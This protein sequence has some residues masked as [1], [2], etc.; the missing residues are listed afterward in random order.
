MSLLPQETILGKLEIIEIYEFYD[1]PCLFSCGNIAGQVFLVVW[2]DETSYSDSWLYVPVSRRRLQQVV[3]GGIELRSAF[4]EAEDG[5]VFEITIARNEKKT[6]VLTISCGN[7]QEESLP[8]S[9]EFLNCQSQFV[10]SLIEKKN[11]KI[12]AIQLN[13]VVLNL[14]FGFPTMDIMQAPIADLG[15]LLQSTQYLI[16]ALGQLKAGKPTVKGA[17]S[18]NITQ[19]TRLTAVGTFE[20]SFGVE[21]V[22]LDRPDLLGY[23]LVEDAVEAFWKLIKIGKDADKLREF[24]LEIKPRAASRYRVFLEKL[25]YS[26][27]RI[28]AEWGSFNQDKG[29]SAEL[30]LADAKIALEI[31]SQV[32]SEQPIQYEVDCELIGINKRT[33]SFEIW[34]ITG[35]RKKYSGKILDSAFTIAETATLSRIYTAIIR[36]II[37]ISVIGEEKIKYELV[38]LKIKT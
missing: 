34:E 24:V 26:K 4:S 13:R 15:I 3:T 35:V 2:V 12:S 25:I 5:F 33:K 32:E 17:I 20:S 19:Q 27:A 9:G 8:A 36:E 31:V 30:L 38:D 7:L 29:D 23:S 10:H 16:D 1:K 18:S 6:D 14:A 28:R 22:A 11:A 21:M 37:E